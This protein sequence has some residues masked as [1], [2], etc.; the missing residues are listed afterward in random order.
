MRR[1]HYIPANLYIRIVD[2]VEEA[3][4]KDHN[5]IIEQFPFYQ[6]LA[7]KWQTKV[8]QKVFNDFE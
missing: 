1:A 7:P 6:R 2:N 5:L 8:I 4:A 3:F